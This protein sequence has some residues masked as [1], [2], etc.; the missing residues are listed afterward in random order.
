MYHSVS[1]REPGLPARPYN[2]TPDTFRK[3]LLGLLKSGHRFVKLSEVLAA[4][5]DG[6][7]L[8]RTVVLTFDDVYESVYRHAFPIMKE[9]RVPGA[10]FLSTA[11]V[12]SLD[13][14]PFDE[15]AQAHQSHIPPQEFRPL[16][17]AQC[18]EMQESGCFEFGA[19][20]H[21][22]L[23]FR[24]KT[25]SFR[26]DLVK[27]IEI[28]RNQFQLQTVPFA[29]PFGATGQGYAGGELRLAAEAAGATC[30]LTTDGELINPATDDPYAWG[31]LAVFEWDTSAT[32][33]AKLANWY[34]L[35]R[36]LNDLRNCF[37]RQ[38]P[39]STSKVSRR[40]QFPAR[41]FSRGG[42]SQ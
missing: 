31:R 12:G 30:A 25:A 4:H 17:W 9:L 24:G 40:L 22:H 32:L 14:F 16:N 5:R 2:V 11:F 27:S 3:Q 28:L 7:L 19:H 42:T 23:D 1:P 29:F 37:R 34:C 8:P 15:W 41:L 10:A 18:H 38:S 36:R 6:V 33:S 26:E 39:S 20:T 35:A 13:P 21:S